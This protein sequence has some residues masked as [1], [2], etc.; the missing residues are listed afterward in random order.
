MD[1]SECRCGFATVSLPTGAHAATGSVYGT[2]L[3][4]ADD[5]LVTQGCVALTLNGAASGLTQSWP[6]AQSNPLE[7]IKSYSGFDSMRR[8][9]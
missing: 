3:S 5:T 8:F 4:A 7:N 6:P 2:I 1:G 9:R